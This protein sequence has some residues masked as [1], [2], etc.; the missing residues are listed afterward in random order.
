MATPAALGGIHRQPPMSPHEIQVLIEQGIEGA[1]A[2]VE[3]E[4][5]KF[6]ATVVSD[7]FEGLSPVKKQQLVYAT[8]NPHIASGVI[9]AITMQTFTRAEWDKK[10]KLGF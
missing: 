2:I 5:N 10:Q 9:H 4:G 6:Q 8:I 3:G 1:K 7:C